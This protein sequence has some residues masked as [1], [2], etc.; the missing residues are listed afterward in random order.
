MENVSSVGFLDIIQ[1]FV[2]VL[3]FLPFYMV[4][5]MESEHFGFI[6]EFRFVE[7]SFETTG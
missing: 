6:S 1:H 4:C 2:T 3:K 7:F 5:S